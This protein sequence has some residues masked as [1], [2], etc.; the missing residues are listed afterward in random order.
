MSIC[1]YN[2]CY[3]SYLSL[4]SLIIISTSFTSFLISLLCFLFFSCD[5]TEAPRFYNGLSS[6]ELLRSC[7]MTFSCYFLVA[8]GLTSF[9][10]DYDFLE[11]DFCSDTEDALFLIP[12]DYPCDGD[13]LRGC[14]AFCC[15]DDL[16][17]ELVRR[18]SFYA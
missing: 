7:L 6:T 15:C 17:S 1:I 16:L 4:R 10:F 5:L 11:T 14:L 8:L 18:G 3:G 12:G 13:L 2:S 9:C